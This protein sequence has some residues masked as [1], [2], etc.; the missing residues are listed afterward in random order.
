MSAQKK[1]KDNY[2]TDPKIT[3]NNAKDKLEIKTYLEKLAKL[4]ESPENQEKAAN[5]ISQMINTPK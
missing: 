5:I 2:P 3:R 1:F 4:L